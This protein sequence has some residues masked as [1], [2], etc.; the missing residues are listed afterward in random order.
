MRV[1]NPSS[2]SPYTGYLYSL[3]SSTDYRARTTVIVVVGKRTTHVVESTINFAM[4]GFGQ[5]L[6]DLLHDTV[7]CPA[8]SRMWIS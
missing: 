5:S 2:L 8:A 4:R 7:P 1:S 6:F 3:S